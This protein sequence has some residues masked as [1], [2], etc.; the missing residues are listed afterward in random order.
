MAGAIA[1]E[2]LQAGLEATRFTGVAATRKV[3]GERGTAWLEELVTT[4]FLAE[5]MGSYVE[6][7]RNVQTAKMAKLTIPGY[8]TASDLAWWGQLAW[9]GAV[10]G[11]LSN[12][13]VYTY[14]FSPTVASDDL[15]FATFEGYSDT[16]AFQIPG[17]A[18]EKFEVTWAGGKAVQFTADLIGQQAKAQAIT[19]GITDRTGLN[20]LAGTSAKV[21]IDSGGGTIGSTQ[22][23]NVLSG[24]ITWTNNFHQITHLQGNLYPDDAYRLPRSVALELDIHYNTDTERLAFDAGTE[25]LISVVF[26]GPNIASSSPTTP[27]S[28]TLQ[29]YGYWETAAFGVSS[30]IRTL[31][32]TGKS[33]YDTGAGFDWKAIIANAV[34]ALP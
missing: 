2:K 3:Y 21:Y 18:V 10:T 25:R 19:A 24:K 15:K 17:C 1:L 31:K 13:S 7:Y 9:K 5:N 16:Q 33:Q 23:L 22:A 27:E 11:V 30:A 32:L 12:T 34:A 26:T 29:F 20:A 4:E 14:T 8:V 6:H 28:V